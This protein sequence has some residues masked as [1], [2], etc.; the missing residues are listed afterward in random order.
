METLISADELTRERIR[1]IF[2]TAYYETKP[3]VVDGEDIE[4]YLIIDMPTVDIILQVDSQYR[5]ISLSAYIHREEPLSALYQFA[6][7]LNRKLLW[8]KFAVDDEDE[9]DYGLHATQTITYKGGLSPS[10]LVNIVRLF[11]EAVN[12]GMRE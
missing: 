10:N 5:H 8:A 7:H 12:L 3:L 11:D 2:S 6:N 1:D 4:N 9:N